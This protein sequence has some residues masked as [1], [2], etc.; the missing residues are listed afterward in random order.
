M[1]R[2]GDP[3]RKGTMMKKIAALALLLLLLS[4]Y[5]P[6]ASWS[7]SS[8]PEFMVDETSSKF[9]EH[10]S[11][12]DDIDG[13][14]T[15][16]GYSEGLNKR[17]EGG[18]IFIAVGVG[19]IQAPRKSP[20]YMRSRVNAFDKAMMS[21]KK[22][23]VEYMGVDI[24]NKVLSDYSEGRSPEAIKKEQQDAVNALKEPGII[25]KTEGLINA[26]LDQLLAKEGVDL[27]RPVPPEA[28]KKVLT[29]EVF[30]KSTQSVASA[31]IV[32]I[33]PWKVFEESPDGAKGE[34]GVIA[35]YS[36]KLHRMAD[37][38]F[39]MG[40]SMLPVGVPKKPIFDQIPKDTKVLLTTFGVQQKIDENGRL[41]LVSFGQDV[42]ATDST[43][44]LSA[45]YEKAKMDAM[46]NMR[47]FAGEIAVV[48]NDLSQYEAVKEFEDGMEKY[49][50]EEYFREKIRTRGEALKIAGIQKVHQWKDVHPL[51]NQPVVGVVISWSPASAVDA[52]KVKQQVENEPARSQ[53]P[54]GA[55][56]KSESGQEGNFSGAGEAA[57][58]DSF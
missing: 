25:E 43:R 41:V 5:G 51:T 55:T 22:Q 31:R 12:R 47:S 33:Q 52:A 40:T 20:S 48:E 9:Q 7:A 42:P 4:F 39:S 44:S 27:S 2:T 53:A 45:A 10:R 14:L 15:S 35:V 54:S 57:D 11:V 3:S 1:M 30:E 23:M 38:L 34:I 36:E 18:D 13:F 8:A 21:A 46:S 26:K 24:R 6:S 29:S 56:H 32:G 50:N 58:E 28:L 49:E 19:V 37:A 17:N 16:R